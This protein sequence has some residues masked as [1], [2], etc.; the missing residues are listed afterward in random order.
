M[1]ALEER[2]S[3][4]ENEFTTKYTQCIQCAFVTDEPFS[5]ELYQQSKPEF[6]LNS[7]RECPKFKS[8]NPIIISSMDD[9]TKEIAGGI[10]GLCTGDFLG[11]PVEFGTRTE[12]ILDPVTELRAYGTYNQYFGVWSDDT[13]LSLCLTESLCEGYNPSDIASKFIKYADEGYWT[14]NGKAFD[15]GRTIKQSIENMKEGKPPLLCGMKPEENNGNGA[16]MRI[17]PAAYLLKN[18]TDEKVKIRIVE[19]ICSLTHAHPISKLACIFYTET[20]IRLLKKDLPFL[21]YANAIDFVLKHC[22]RMYE[23]VMPL[24]SRVFSGTLQ[25]MPE[26]KV[27]SGGFVVE[28]LE[29]AMWS[30]LKSNKYAECVLKAVNLGEDT[31]SIASIA[32]GLGGIYYGIENIPENWL[33]MAARKEDILTLCKTFA[34]K[35]YK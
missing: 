31:D 22:S 20:A 9:K 15:M 21:A 26:S 16:L 28:S 2:W 1:S 17:L 13:S 19:E 12:R 7:Q 33:N 3:P 35:V 10:F 25:I 11:L 34:D 14:P 29:A 32:G 8:N 18:E 5:C 24:Y 27:K 4:E 6:V 23:M 30:F